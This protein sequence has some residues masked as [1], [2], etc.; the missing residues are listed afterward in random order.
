MNE[1][2]NEAAKPHK[3]EDSVHAVELATFD[4]GA[5]TPETAEMVRSTAVGIRNSM[6]QVLSEVIAYGHA[7]LRVQ[8]AL[9]YGAFGK[10]LLSE[11]GWDRRTAQNYMR[12]AEAFGQMGN[13]VSHLPLRVIYKLATQPPATREYILQ[14]GCSEAQISAEIKIAIKKR[15]KA[16]KAKRKRA[17]GKKTPEQLE[18]ELL[19]REREEQ[20]AANEAVHLLCELGGHAPEK[21]GALRDLINRSVF[22]F[23]D[24]LNALEIAAL[25]LRQHG[26]K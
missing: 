8:A 15:A 25:P 4:Y 24:T 2:C 19:S 26:G 13:A 14:T 21:I 5:L 6:R 22:R 10:W 17:Y 9:P 18:Q 12:V 20:A 1:A 16:K 3:A 7:L 23:L 11:F